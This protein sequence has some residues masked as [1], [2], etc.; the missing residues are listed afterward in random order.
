MTLRLLS[1]NIRYG[2]VGREDAI[3]AVVRA[4]AP[5]IVVF[6]EATR[7]AVVERVAAATGM[8]RWGSR[9][10]FSVGFMSRLEVTHYEWHRPPPC[11]RAFLEL[12]PAG[13][14]ARIFGVH[15]SAIN[16]NWMERR[17]TRELNALLA[18]IAE[19]QHGFHVLAGDFNTLAPGEKFNWRQLP[20][21]LQLLAWIGGRAIRW[22][23]VQ[24]M[25]DAR[26]VDGF[27]SLHPEAE[28]YTFPTWD[29]HVRLD[30][31]FVPGAAAERLRR[32][33]VV[34]GPG[35]GSASDHLPLLAELEI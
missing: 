10:G 14:E 20:R 7:P 6:Q 13:S 11:R 23:T 21:R 18:E 24:I 33:E 34:D 31:L 19:H 25:L 4:A 1:Y 3:A 29:P 12:V 8:A 27:R 26:Y 15:L 28:G 32:C 2:G 9:P 17:R 22:Q 5:D 30:Y 16:S 35:A